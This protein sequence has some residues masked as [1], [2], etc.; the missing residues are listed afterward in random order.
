MP[1]SNDIIYINW[2]DIDDVIIVSTDNIIYE[3]FLKDIKGESK[4]R[5]I[6]YIIPGHP[7]FMK[8]HATLDIIC[9]RNS[10]FY[11]I[12]N[13]KT[14]NKILYA[15]LSGGKIDGEDFILAYK[16]FHRNETINKIL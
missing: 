7:N 4:V 9:I 3:N 2:L 10:I 1:E 14:L 6:R 5:I 15:K 13:S 12:E 8:K 16:R 11:E